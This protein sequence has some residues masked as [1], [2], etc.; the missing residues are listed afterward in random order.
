MVTQELTDP[1]L[2][3]ADGAADQVQRVEKIALEVVEPSYLFVQMQ[4]VVFL[5]AQGH[6]SSSRLS[7]SHVQELVLT[8]PPAIM[9]A[10]YSSLI[11]S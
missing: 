8:H 11:R 7:F 1:A 5:G 9:K 3:L 4:D 6:S 10:S 2:D